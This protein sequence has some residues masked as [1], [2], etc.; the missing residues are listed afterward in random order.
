MASYMED[1]LRQALT[2]GWKGKF[3]TQ[4]I[5]RYED[6]EFV[7]FEWVQGEAQRWE[8]VAKCR[9]WDGF[10]GEVEYYLIKCRVYGDDL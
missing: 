5:L 3:G 9:E 1:V 8:A 10:F 7:M 6:G 4:R 2:S